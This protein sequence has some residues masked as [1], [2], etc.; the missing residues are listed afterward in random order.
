MPRSGI[1]NSTGQKISRH[2]RPLVSIHPRAP[3]TSLYKYVRRVAGHK[4]QARV[5][6]HLATTTGVP[7]RW[8]GTHVNLGLYT[9]ERDA[10]LAVV[11]YVRTGKRPAHL[12]PRYIFACARDGEYPGMFV[13][14]VRLKGVGM[15]ATKPQAT[16]EGADAAMRK[17]LRKMFGVEAEGRFYPFG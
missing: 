5:Y 6:Y 2:R 9:E 3:R 11:E 13:G 12:L 4:F 17:L 8:V 10:W 14:R 15:V 7:G 1:F 16:V